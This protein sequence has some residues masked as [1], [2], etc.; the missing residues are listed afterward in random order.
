MAAETLFTIYNT[1]T[2]LPWLLLWV[3]PKWK[4]T[5][6]MAKTQLPVIILAASYL[7]FIVWSFTLPDAPGVDFSDFESIRTAFARPEV[8]LV[9]WI[10]YLA[11]DLAV[12]MWEFR[13]AQKR[14]MPH[15][16]LLPCLFLTLMFGPVGYLLY[17]LVRNRFEYT[18]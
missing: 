14:A 13:D 5:Q 12:G 4:G 1:A 2:L 17:M 3:A 11:F 9:G 10:H 18:V 6:W 15:W 8:L 16:A 7:I